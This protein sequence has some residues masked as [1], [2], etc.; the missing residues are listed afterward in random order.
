MVKIKRPGIDVTVVEFFKPQRVPHRIQAPLITTPLQKSIPGFITG[1]SGH[2]RLNGLMFARQYA[3]AHKLEMIVV[4]LLVAFERPLYTRV[5]PPE[6][7]KDH[8]VLNMMRINKHL[9]EKIAGYWQQ[10]VVA[11]EGKKAENKYDWSRPSGFVARRP[12]LIAKL[13]EMEEFH[14][15]EIVTH[16]VMTAFSDQ[17]LTATSLRANYPSIV[18]ANAR[19]HPD[20]EVCCSAVDG[21]DAEAADNSLLP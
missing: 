10:W 4:D 14:H 13:L 16:P 21:A 15:I 1:L 20:I 17:P 12:D 9:V 5:M 6:A 7:I 18:E 11:S 19:F 8:D 2:Q 3:D